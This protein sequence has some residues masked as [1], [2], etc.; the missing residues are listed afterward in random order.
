MKN[1]G[2]LAMGPSLAPG[3]KPRCCGNYAAVRPQQINLRL[4][5]DG[6]AS[7][8]AKLSLKLNQGP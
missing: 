7:A 8:V 1:K 3:A 4:Q 5:W 2:I 6:G